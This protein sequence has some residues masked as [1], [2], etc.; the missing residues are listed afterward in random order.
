MGTDLKP[1]KQKDFPNTTRREVCREL[2]HRGFVNQADAMETCGQ[3]FKYISCP[4]CGARYAF[5]LRC[6]MKLCP[7]CGES[8]IYIL[9]QR[10]KP[11]F[12]ELEELMGDYRFRRIGLSIRPVDYDHYSAYPYKLMGQATTNLFRSKLVK[13]AFG[14]HGGGIWAIETKQRRKGQTYRKRKTG[15][16]SDPTPR[17]SFYIHVH[18]MIFS[19]YISKGKLSHTWRGVTKRLHKKTGSSLLKGLYKVDIDEA[20]VVYNGLFETVK[21]VTKPPSMK[22]AEDYAK[23][24]ETTKNMRLLRTLG[25]FRGPRLGVKGEPHVPHCGVCSEEIDKRQ[26]GFET[27]D[28]ETAVIYLDDQPLFNGRLVAHDPF[29]KPE[30]KWRKKED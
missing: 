23:Y 10:F 24:Y 29:F 16:I 14:E 2:I 25:S 5:P 13:D 6:K 1:I 8:Q 15:E 22:S 3:Y 17:D 21:Y 4:G 11:V 7:N 27:M 12:N 19:K 9:K 18:G 28:Y 30:L 20:E 26:F